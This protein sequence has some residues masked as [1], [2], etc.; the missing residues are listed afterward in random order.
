MSNSIPMSAMQSGNSAKF[1][2]FGDKYGGKV[3]AVEQRAQTDLG[4]KPLLYDD[5]TQRMQWVVTLEQDNGETV[6]LYARG[7]NYEADQGSGESMLKAFGVACEAVG[8]DGV[9]VGG[10]LD[11]A[12]TGLQNLSGGRTAKLYTARYAA[13]KAPSIPA[14]DLFAS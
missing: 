13:P 11:V 10:R 8:A 2:K 4:G 1:E 9:A 7:G 5:G 6:M 3:I 14:D 12:F